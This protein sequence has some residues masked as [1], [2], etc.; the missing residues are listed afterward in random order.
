[1]CPVAA[2]IMASSQSEASAVH[3]GLVA[4]GRDPRGDFKIDT[5]YIWI[6]I[7]KMAGLWDYVQYV[8]IF[9][10]PKMGAT[11]PRVPKW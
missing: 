11:S 8:S 2:R 6:L 10:H 1:M 7:H 4:M 3:G 5:G 9:T